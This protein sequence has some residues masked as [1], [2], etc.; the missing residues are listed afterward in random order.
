M[1]ADVNR[2]L[3]RFRILDAE[4]EEVIDQSPEYRA[5]M[6]DQTLKPERRSYQ[7]RALLRERADDP[8]GAEASVAIKQ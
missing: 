3:E 2:W 7:Y 6:G 8:A 5:L 1:G 4:D